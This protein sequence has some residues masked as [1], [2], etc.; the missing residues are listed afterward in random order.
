MRRNLILLGLVAAGALTAGIVGW[1]HLRRDP[2]LPPARRPM[3]WAEFRALYARPLAPPAGPLRVF[4]LGH[5]LVGHDMPAMLAQIAGPGHHYESQIGRGTTLRAHWEDHI[6]IEGYAED[7]DH[8]RFR[9]AK[10][11]LA[12]GDYDAVVLTE[13][14]EIRTS[15]KEEGAAAYLA[16]WAA[17]AR[18]A[19]PATRVYLYET[20]H[21][22]S[23]SEG[24]L[25]RLDRDLPRHWIGAVMRGAAAYPGGAPV[26]LIPA[27]QVLA[28]IARAAEAGEVPGIASR[29]D[30]F[31]RT[32][33]GK[34]DKIHIGDLGAFLVALTHHAVLYG[35][36]PP[37]LMSR[38][39][40]ADGA[41]ADLPEALD[42]AA[43]WRM[44]RE[45][46]SAL[47]ETGM[48]QS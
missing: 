48:R 17:L 32:A 7:N 14:V 38:M 46:A 25:E 16:L 15:I 30:F 24:W 34:L 20:W 33:E 26:Y 5:S 37:G 36:E 42:R 47:P 44:V 13:R 10:E 23:D 1:R 35:A 22:L 12:S 43:L 11:A 21:W 41:P 9:S 45:V 39:H 31:A 28:R 40:R 8:D 19:N 29:E 27:G 6:P 3:P 2:T 18:Q 4:H